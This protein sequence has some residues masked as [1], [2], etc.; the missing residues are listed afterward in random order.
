MSALAAGRNPSI[1]SWAKV[2]APRSID[3]S[4]PPSVRHTAPCPRHPTPRRPCEIDQRQALPQCRR[5]GSGAKAGLC[6]YGSKCRWAVFYR[7]KQ[8]SEA[9]RNAWNDT[10]QYFDRMAGVVAVVLSATAL[11]G[12]YAPPGTYPVAEVPSAQPE[13]YPPAVVAPSPYAASPTSPSAF[14]SPQY[15]PTTL[16]AAPPSS[17]GATTLVAAPYGPPPLRAENPPPPPSPMAIWQPGRWSWDGGQYVWTSGHYAQRPT[18]TANWLPGY[19]QQGP[20]GW[21]WI[22]GHWA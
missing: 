20:S 10:M 16:P 7:Q 6:S 15:G 4:C 11:S 5:D 17:A 3:G 18:P 19:W 8:R 2:S 21:I 12:C 13:P 22:E 9:L 1:E 14:A